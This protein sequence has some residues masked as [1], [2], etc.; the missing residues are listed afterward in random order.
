VHGD[1]ADT[2]TGGAEGVDQGGDVTRRRDADRVAERELVA[3]EVGQAGADGNDL[4]NRYVALPRIAVAHRHVPAYGQTRVQRP[5]YH[6]LEHRELVVER[7]VEVLHRE[8][9]GGAGEDRDL[10]DTCLQGAVQAALVRHQYGCP[11]AGRQIDPGQQ[12]GGVGEL[13]HP[14]GVDEAGGLDRG[15]PGRGQP[16]DELGLDLEVDDRV[17]V[18]Q[19]V[20]RPDLVDR[21]PLRQTL[22]PDPLWFTHRSLSRLKAQW[23]P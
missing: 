19:P 14:L 20:A 23:S 12:F 13:G 5:P 22:G 18:L 17:L 21:H 11:D 16:V 8:R 1:P 10:G 6:R 2:D 4:R 3:A 15:Q 7:R 9:L